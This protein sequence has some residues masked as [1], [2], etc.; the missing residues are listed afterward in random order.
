MIKYLK[1]N[2]HLSII[3][4][5]P[6]LISGPFL[7]D[8][9]VSLSAIIFLILVI[10]N[11]EYSYF[12]KKPIIIFFIF[13]A[14]CIFVSIFYAEN[15]LLSFESSLFYFRIGIF[16]CLIWY[17]INK[18]KKIL[19]YFYYALIL[20]FFILALDGYLQFFTG[21]N[22]L[23]YYI[24]E[25]NRISSFF[26][27]ELILGSYLSRLYPLLLAL[28]F[29]KSFNKFELS[30]LTIFFL[31]ISIL[32]YISGERTSFSNHIMSLFLILTLTKKY[33]KF[34]ILLA[35]S[36]ILILSSFIMSDNPINK[37]M[38]KDPLQSMRLLD[39]QEKKYIFSSTHDSLI[40]TAYNMF[41]DQPLFG[42]GPKMFRI[43]C[44]KEKYAV[45]EVP[46]MTHPHN[47]YIQ[48]LAETG[49]IGFLFLFSAF[50][51][52]FYCYLKHLKSILFK[53]K[54]YLNDYQV[55]LLAGILITL[56]PIAPNGNFF[57][58]WLA[59]CYSLPV[60][61]YLNSIYGNKE[62]ILD[63]KFNKN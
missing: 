46:C 11:K 52:V 27:D 38:L 33:F 21:K 40:R 15:I 24:F 55:C 4:L 20:C 45:G 58:N 29:I 16:A 62:K 48:L 6:F 1:K 35:I 28:F 61:F 7:S 25:N 32:I 17:T 34:K 8:L 30:Y 63:I 37:R 41:K 10:N 2:S 60:G 26:G 49:I 9:L 47:F 54:R 22:I 50:L 44:K 13:C 51:Y 31:S 59:I 12:N 3:F 42:H 56:W 5:I 57:N 23:G 53:Q 43:L 18:D 36:F 14:Y 19:D 39:S